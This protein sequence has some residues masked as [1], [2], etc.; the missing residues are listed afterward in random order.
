MT[1][2]ERKG[3]I[4]VRN[5]KLLYVFSLATKTIAE[6]YEGDV[7]CG[8]SNP[9]HRL[10]DV[11]HAYEIVDEDEMNFACQWTS[12]FLLPFAI[13]LGL[14]GIMNLHDK[15]FCRTH[16][17]MKLFEKIPNEIQQYMKDI[18]QAY[19]ILSDP[20]KRKE[21]DAEHGFNTGDATTGPYKDGNK[22]GEWRIRYADGSVEYERY[23]N[24]EEVG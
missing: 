12:R 24:H 23:D 18:N 21:Y 9:I 8:H 1:E 20:E 4:L 7:A 5:A 17:L 10:Y 13:E 15:K 2:K 11:I 22:H 3:M 16:D 6:N 14:K 19:Q